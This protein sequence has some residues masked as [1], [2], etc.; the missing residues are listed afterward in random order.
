MLLSKSLKMDGLSISAIIQQTLREF[1]WYLRISPGKGEL[2]PGNGRKF[3]FDFFG[4]NAGK[5]LIKIRNNIL[6]FGLAFRHKI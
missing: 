3:P 4:K 5:G 2:F 6:C 1:K